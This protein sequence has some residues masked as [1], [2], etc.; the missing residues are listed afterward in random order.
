MAKAAIKKIKVRKD[1]FTLIE[2]LV[3]I[4]IIG[5]LAALLLPALEIAM[6][7]ARITKCVSNL[8][9]L[10]IG[11][12]MYADDNNGRYPKGG[13]GFKTTRF[14]VYYALF[15]DIPANMSYW[16]SG[17]K[18]KSYVENQEL[19]WCPNYKERGQE[20]FGPSY[21]VTTTGLT[22]KTQ[23]PIFD[24]IEATEWYT[25][26]DALMHEFAD[27]QWMPPGNHGIAAGSA[28]CSPSSLTGKFR[29]KS[30]GGSILHF[31]GGANFYNLEQWV[32]EKHF[33]ADFADNTNH[34]LPQEQLLY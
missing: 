29:S 9:Q 25:W 1:G 12:F 13:Q 15:S 34:K 19:F 6:E 21:M 30:D 33:F 26:Q 27:A 5:I 23:P 32:E 18:H 14:G 3:V 24:P 28:G 4:A 8:K 22:T 7:Q 16:D 11:V 17:E 31:H 10:G 20:G 2:L